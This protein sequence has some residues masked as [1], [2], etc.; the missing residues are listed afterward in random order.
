M[1]DGAPL[2]GAATSEHYKRHAEFEKWRAA[3][4]WFSLIFL[5]HP[6]A[7]FLERARRRAANRRRWG[8]DGFGFGAGER[9]APALC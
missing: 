9:R 7:S 6:A 2:L 8:S 1:D 3:V 5:V 4:Y